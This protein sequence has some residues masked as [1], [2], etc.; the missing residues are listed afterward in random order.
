MTIASWRRFMVLGSASALLHYLAARWVDQ[1]PAA[2]PRVRNKAAPVIAAL[3]APEPAA[4]SEGTAPGAAGEA[5]A[6]VPVRQV[7]SARKGGGG[8]RY[9]ASLPPPAELTLDVSRID[10]QGGSWTGQAVLEWRLDGAAYR[11][12]YRGG[13]AEMA[14]EGRVGA[15]GIIPRTMTEKRR[16]RARTATHF[17]E[18]GNITFSA[19]QAAVPMQRGAQDR[20]TLPLQLA[21]IARA[22]AAQLVA[23]VAILVGAEKDA[24]LYRFVVQGQ[25][26]IETGIGKLATWRL[27][28]VPPPG[29]Y[30]A[31]L[32]IWLAPGYEWY[33]VQLRSTEANGTVTTQT[34]RKIVVTDAGN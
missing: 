1:G 21:A 7:Q 32:D 29:T 8:R 18:Q 5:S 20:A 16:N 19:A 3:R 28:R 11:L 12:Q 17:D 27:A 26:E 13:V 22:D 4:R 14:S 6:A 25:E 9:R 33:P 23:G 24:T 34:I 10:A 15:A 30:N 31:R 2:P